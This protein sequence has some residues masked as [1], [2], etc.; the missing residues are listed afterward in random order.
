M[1]ISLILS[2]ANVIMNEVKELSK[3]ETKTQ[4]PA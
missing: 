3:Y 2:E 4:N 1:K